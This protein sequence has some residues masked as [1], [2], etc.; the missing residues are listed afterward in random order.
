M[1]TLVFVGLGNPGAT[2][3]KTRHNLGVR[4]L[5]TWVVATLQQLAA[6]KVWQESG[7]VERLVLEVPEQQAGVTRVHAVFP[8]TFMNKSG[9]AIRD[10]M[11]SEHLPLTSLLIL[12]DDIELPIGEVR[13]QRGGSA[14][15]HNGMRSMYQQLG[16]QTIARV[17]LGIGRPDDMPVDQYVLGKF[18]TP[19][20]PLVQEIMIKAHEVL[21]KICRQGIDALL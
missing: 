6:E 7:L 11:A 3:E 4:T 1:Q 5:K 16:E 21:A 12:H 8:L 19:E 2:Y 20:E 18:T 10:Y 15:G 9:E 13:L 14:K 17:R